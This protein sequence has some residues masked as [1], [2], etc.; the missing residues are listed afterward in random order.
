MRISQI[1]ES[2]PHPLLTQGILVVL[3]STRLRFPAVGAK[4]TKLFATAYLTL[5]YSKKSG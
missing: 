4:L 2:I 1:A 3:R 5:L